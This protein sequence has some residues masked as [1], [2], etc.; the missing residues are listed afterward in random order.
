MLAMM[1]FSVSLRANSTVWLKPSDSDLGD[2]VHG[3]YYV[4]E[5]TANVPSGEKFDNAKIS[6]WGIYNRYWWEKNTL[7]TQLLGPD[8]IQGIPFT[9]GI[10][11]GSDPLADFPDEVHNND[12]AQYGGT[13]MFPDGWGDQQYSDTDGYPDNVFYTFDDEELGVLNSYIDGNT[14]RF[15][16]GFDPDCWFRFRVPDSPNCKITFYGQTVP[17]VPAPGAVLLGG[18]GVGIVGWMRKRKTL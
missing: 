5:I 16:I 3:N 12:I 10:Y 9:N 2:F 7:Y 8:D 15:A 14:L 17:V 6:I 13:E 18:I 4:W 1:V 11:T